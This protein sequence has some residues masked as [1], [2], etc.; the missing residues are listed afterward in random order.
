MDRNGKKLPTPYGLFEQWARNNLNGN[1]STMK[2]RGGFYVAVSDLN[3]C[4]L[5]SNRFGVGG[6]FRNKIGKSTPLLLKYSNGNYAPL[7]ASLGYVV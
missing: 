5:I 3:D 2:I 7:A 4:Q 6:P 1:W